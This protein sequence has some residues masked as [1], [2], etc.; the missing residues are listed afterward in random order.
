ME[1]KKRDFDMSEQIAAIKMTVER[2]ESATG[3]R[4]VRLPMKYG[5]DYLVMNGNEP[6]AVAEIKCRDINPDQYK[7]YGISLRK[8]ISGLELASIFGVPFVLYVKFANGVI[9]R[10]TIMASMLRFVRVAEK[11]NNERG[12]IEPIVRFETESFEWPKY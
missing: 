11:S 8:C 1:N 2:I 3:D 6:V 12:D 4:F 9:G 7:D 10:K 5:V